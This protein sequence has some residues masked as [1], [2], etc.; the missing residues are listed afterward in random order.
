MVIEAFV[1]DVNDEPPVTTGFT[2]GLP[3]KYYIGIAD[4]VPYNTT[5]FQL[6]VSSVL[7]IIGNNSPYA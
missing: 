2:Q 3:N 6:N 1:V 7:C 5:I 4:N